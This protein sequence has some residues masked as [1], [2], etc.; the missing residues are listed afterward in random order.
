MSATNN[1]VPGEIP[2]Q[3]PVTAGQ[4]APDRFPPTSRY[5]STPV[6]TVTDADGSEHRYLTRR[7]IPTAGTATTLAEHLVTAGDRLDLLAQRYYGDP[8]LSWR[9]AD[10]NRALDPG[11]LTSTPGAVVTIASPDLSGQ[12]GGAP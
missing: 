3:P 5:A 7:F 11:Q 8:L 1:Q 6:V 12:F 9:I 4:L 2:G 10:A